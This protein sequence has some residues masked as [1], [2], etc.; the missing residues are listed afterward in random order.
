MFAEICAVAIAYYLTARLGRLAAPPPGIETVVWP[1]S[2]IALAALL[3]LGNRIW[4]GIWLGAFLANN[5]ASLDLTNPSAAMGMLATGAGID[6]GSLLQSLFGASMLRRF[7]GARNPFDSVKDTLAFVGIAHAMCLLGSACGV[8]S[9]FVGGF[10]SPERVFQRWLNWWIGDAGGV[11][12]VAPAILTCWY[13][14]WPRWSHARWREAVLLY[15]AVVLSAMAVFVWW[16]PETEDKF[17]ADLLILPMIAWVAVRFTLREVTLLVLLV[18]GIAVAGTIQGSGPYGGTRPGTLCPSCKH[19]SESCRFFR[20]RSAPRSPSAA[21][22]KRR[23]RRAS[24][25]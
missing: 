21:A 18:L 7:V 25:G 10:L 22:P 17:P 11:L 24:I 15:S 19:L 8:T 20:S 12:I 9:L 1:P 14:G 2:G 16:R 4:P 6:T 3:I 13:L 5:W 23:Y